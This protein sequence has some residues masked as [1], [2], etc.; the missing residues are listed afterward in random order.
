MLRLLPALLLLAM[1]SFAQAEQPRVVT[2][3]Q[4]LQQIATAVMDGIAP[5]EVM[6]PPGASPHSYALRPSDR[7]MLRS[8]DRIYWVGPQLELFLQSLLDGEGTAVALMDVDG[9]ETRTYPERRNFQQG[10]GDQKP[11]HDGHAGHDHAQEHG[12]GHKHDHDHKHEH[13]GDHSSDHDSHAD[14]GHGG[15]EHDHDHAPGTLDEHIW[16]SPTNAQVIARFMAADLTELFPDHAEQL[17]ANLA[18]FEARLETLDTQL[19]ERFAPLGDKGYFVFHDAYGYFEDHYG[20]KA[21][22][23]FTLSH[24]VQPGARQVNLL[25]QQL[26]ESGRV[27]VFT[28]PQ[29][30]PR[31]VN[32]LTRD[33]PVEAGELDPLG[34]GIAVGPEGYIALLQQL[35]DNLAGCLERL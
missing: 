27:C 18:T 3:I 34:V 35:A 31:L 28:E 11:A 5:V 24:E 17:A 15:H 26:S 33:L 23:V 10:N 8:A 4:P 2:T 6:L 7:R 19:A 29:F 12:H 14:H 25:R 9:L 21:K 20:I 32:S 30:T 16:L 13:D 22:G 1:S